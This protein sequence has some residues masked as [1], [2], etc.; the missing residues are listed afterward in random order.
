MDGPR[1]TTGQSSG[2]PSSRNCTAFNFSIR[3]RPSSR[4]A[5]L[6]GAGEAFSIHITCLDS[7]MRRSANGLDNVGITVS[8]FL[9]LCLSSPKIEGLLSRRVCSK[10]TNLWISRDGSNAVGNA[11]TAV[12]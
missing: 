10:F 6:L 5:T 9:L 8:L 3:R 7:H 2:I 1:V 4:A 11:F 12:S